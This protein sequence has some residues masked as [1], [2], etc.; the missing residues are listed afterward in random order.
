VIQ[1]TRLRHDDALYLN[2]DLFE[3]VDT[4]V[5]TV[6]RLTDGTEYV[7]TEP[8]EEIVRRIIEFRARIIAIAGMMQSGATAWSSPSATEPD[9][10]AS[11][12]ALPSAEA[13]IDDTSSDDTSS[14]EE[15][16]A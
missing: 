10:P 3:R 14:D 2:P 16:T 7:V 6:V 11:L 15:H 9:A 5:D 12:A 13:T 1:L 4:H 8:A